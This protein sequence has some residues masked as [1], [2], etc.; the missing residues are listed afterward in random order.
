MF[1]LGFSLKTKSYK[2]I[3]P[4]LLNWNEL[5]HSKADIFPQKT[6]SGKTSSYFCLEQHLLFLLGNA[7][8][9]SPAYSSTSPLPPL[10]TLNNTVWMKAGISLQISVPQSLLVSQGWA[11]LSQAEPML[12]SHPFGHSW[13]REELAQH[14]LGR[15]VLL[16]YWWWK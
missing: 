9:S 6:T 5:I 12:E 10:S 15:S 4:G 13:K 11:P 7:P 3:L 1:D 2:I 14:K 16:C 8:F